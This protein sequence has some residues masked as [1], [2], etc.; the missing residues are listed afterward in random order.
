MSTDIEHASLRQEILENGKH[1]INVANIVVTLTGAAIVAA[2]Q[3]RNPYIV[4]FPL[5][6]LYY[7]H[8]VL[9]NNMQT[10]VRSSVYLRIVE[11]EKYERILYD[12]R[13]EIQK[14][15][16]RARSNIPRPMRWLKP[17]SILW[18]Q[19]IAPILQAMFIVLGFVCI[20]LSGL[21]AWLVETKPNIAPNASSDL[22]LP[23]A[24]NVIVIVIVF[25][26]WLIVAIRS[27]RIVHP[28][29]GKA[30]MSQQY[31]QAFER[32][33]ATTSSTELQE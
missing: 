9:F 1:A 20:L 27:R 7:G 3:L 15:E 17:H 12:L 23:F 6:A 14:K 13:R 33:M 2:F 28:F 18:E 31:E 29:Y 19:W 10:I 22:V 8:T 21:I 5:F 24:H 32:V 25:F 4:L 26:T 30:N 11:K 16:E